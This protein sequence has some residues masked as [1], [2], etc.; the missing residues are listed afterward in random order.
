MESHE[1][2]DKIYY[3]FNDLIKD[4]EV[5]REEYFLGEKNKKILNVLS[6][7]CESKVTAIEE[8]KDL[9]L[10]PIESLI[11]SL[12]SYELKLKTKVQEEEDAKVKGALL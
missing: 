10:M 12:T 8:T 6:K 7:D 3:K 4:F 9:N 1:K 5:L 11:N 2:I